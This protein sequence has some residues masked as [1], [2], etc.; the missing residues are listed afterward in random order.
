[1]DEVE[2]GSLLRGGRG[3]RIDAFEEEDGGRRVVVV[4]RLSGESVGWRDVRDEVDRERVEE[5]M[6]RFRSEEEEGLRDVEVWTEGDGGPLLVL[7]GEAVADSRSIRRL[8]VP[9]T[10]R[11]E[12]AGP[13]AV[14]IGSEREVLN[15]SAT[16]DSL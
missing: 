6:E 8:G 4:D 9:E 3:G 10:V 7:R 16:F 11:L 1:M 14:E 2:V 15:E 12:V 5:V 13:P